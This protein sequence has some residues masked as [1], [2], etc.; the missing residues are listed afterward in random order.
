[1]KRFKA[2]LLS[3]LAVAAAASAL[4]AGEWAK[5]A[6]QD[7]WMLSVKFETAGFVDAEVPKGVRERYLYVTYTLSNKSTKKIDKARPT[8]VVITDTGKVYYDGGYPEGK[9]RVEK[10]TGKK[11]LSEMKAMGEFKPGERKK[12]ISLFPLKDLKAKQITIQFRGLT[13]HYKLVSE[14]GKK[15]I[16]KR[17]FEVRY[18]WPGDDIHIYSRPLKYVEAKWAWR[19]VKLSKLDPALVEEK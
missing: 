17:V 16:I 10:L 7:F 13:N 9:A 11:F 12:V 15:K 8:V 4:H 1:M 3:F 2:A 6:M 18:D 19:K 14:K 5:L